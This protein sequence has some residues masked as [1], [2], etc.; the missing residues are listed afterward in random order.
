MSRLHTVI[1]CALISL[2]FGVGFASFTDGGIAG[3]LV[4]LVLGLAMFILGLY[5]RRPLY[6]SIA[7]FLMFT[8][9]GILRFSYWRDT[10]RDPILEAS[11][12]EIVLLEGIINDEPAVREGSTQVFVEIYQINLEGV[13][14]QAQGRMQ[15]SIAHYPV[16][17]YGDVVRVSGKL[18]RPKKFSKTDGRVLTTHRILR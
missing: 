9:L 15:I 3:S 12:G 13:R 8:I 5:Y 6:F 2:L 1:T 16:F 7:I 17:M 14:V 10:P 11:I 4:F 18:L